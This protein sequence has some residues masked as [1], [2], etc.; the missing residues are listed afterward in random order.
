MFKLKRVVITGRGAITS[1]GNK[2]ESIM[3]SLINEKSGI[4]I[5]KSY[6][7]NG[8][9]SHVSGNILLD[10]R[11]LINNKKIT[12]FMSEGA[13]YAYLSMLQAI[14]E[15]GLTETIIHDHATGIIFGTGG[16]SAASAIEVGHHLNN[17][18]IRKIKPSYII[19][20][21]SSAPVA[22]LCVL[23]GI[24]GL[25]FSVA[26][27]CASSA[28]AIG[29]AF[30]KIV[31]GKMKVMFAGACDENDAYVASTF[32][33]ARALSRN[34]NPQ[35]ASRPYDQNRDGFVMSG[36]SGILVLEELEHA[37]SRGAHIYAEVIG[38]GATSDGI[39]MTNPSSEGSAACMKQALISGSLHSS[40]INYI[41]TH[42]T[43]TLNGDIKELIAIKKVFGDTLPFISSTKSLTGHGLGASGAQ[44]IIF[45]TIMIENN[46]IAASSN[47]K[48]IDPAAANFP[49]ITE[50]L[51]NVTPKT[52]MSNSFGFGG[53]NATI[54]IRKFND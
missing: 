41:N 3:D 19:R 1:I 12:K 50:C 13:A 53:T 35:T 25:S 46:F 44:E 6:I 49:I 32:D 48:N 30:E 47:I 26:S 37:L 29:E 10:A 34:E 38:Y 28:H 20:S 31:Y 54:I 9:S 39:D 21:M 40:D 17:C 15:S 43:S 18:N 52:I 8:L 27:A 33:R 11:A 45:S 7:Q 22:I 2:I 16:G 36:G 42:G 4:V 24:K 23:F 51:K 5:N 14:E